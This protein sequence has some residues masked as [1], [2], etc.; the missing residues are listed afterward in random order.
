MTKE[1]LAKTFR[2]GNSVALRLPKALGVVEGEEFKIVPH[3]DGGFTI[4]KMSEA[5][6]VF[7]SLAGKLS[8]GFMA[9]GRGDIEQEG[10]D[11]SRGGD[12]VKAA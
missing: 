7:M 8:A 5:L 9:E 1:Y 10:R 6:E 4:I 2:S 11:W 3:A 12:P